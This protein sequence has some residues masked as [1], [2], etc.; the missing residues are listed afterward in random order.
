MYIPFKGKREHNWA[1]PITQFSSRYLYISTY[2]DA[3]HSFVYRSFLD[4]SNLQI[5]IT[6]HYPVLSMTIDYRHPRL[7]VLLSNG[8]IES[9]ATDSSQPWKSTLHQFTSNR[10]YS[11]PWIS[12]S[13]TLLI[14][15]RPYAIDLHDDT[16]VVM[17]FNSTDS[18]YD[19]V[20]IDKFGRTMTEQLRK[21]P[22]PVIIRYVYELKYPTGNTSKCEWPFGRASHSKQIANYSDSNKLFGYFMSQGSHLHV[23]SRQSICLYYSWA[24][25]DESLVILLLMTRMSFP[26]L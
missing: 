6:L 26:L 17:V 1:L 16:L 13:K 14:D 23:H 3:Q 19:E 24:Y 9:Y 4:G 8:E 21:L 25:V 20:W 10:S 15:V 5:F 22:T 11:L 2:Y 12:F 7:Y 18:T